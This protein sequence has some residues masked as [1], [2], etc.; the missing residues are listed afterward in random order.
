MYKNQ[1]LKDTQL[2]EVSVLWAYYTH[3]FTVSAG[4]RNISYNEPIFVVVESS[5]YSKNWGHFEIHLF[6]IYLKKGT[7]SQTTH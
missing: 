7:V 5:L 1:L 3:G 2:K 6:I 4:T